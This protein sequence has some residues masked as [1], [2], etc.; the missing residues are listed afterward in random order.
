M[1]DSN[2]AFSADRPA[3]ALVD[4]VHNSAMIQAI[5]V[6]AELNIADLLANGCGDVGELATATSTHPRSLHRLLRALAS[7]TF[8]VERDDGSFAL[9][10]MGRPLQSA[11]PGSLRSWILWWCGKH[12]WP[13]WGNLLH[14]VMTGESARKFV[15]GSDGFGRLERDPAA[16]AVFNEAMV[17]L[18]RLVADEVARV[19][20]F[21]GM[22]RIVDIGGG[23]GALMAAVLAANPAAGGVLFDRPHAIEGQRLTWP[24]KG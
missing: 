6:A 22:R 5:Y 9:G 4:L 11:A 14:S 10:P 18:T 19:C 3:A 8:C 1:L 17:E 12:Q 20:D 24:S 23:H 16:A 7:L 21:A 13:V 2:E 15:T